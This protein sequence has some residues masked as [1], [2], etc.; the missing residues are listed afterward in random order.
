MQFRQELKFHTTKSLL[1]ILSVLKELQMQL[2]ALGQQTRIVALVGL[3][4]QF[5]ASFFLVKHCGY[6]S[7]NTDG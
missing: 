3:H 5:P 4:T 7:H 1:V 6:N 2:I